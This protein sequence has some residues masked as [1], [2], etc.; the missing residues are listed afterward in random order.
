MP[1]HSV[2][3]IAEQLLDAGA[4]LAGSDPLRLLSRAAS[5]GYF[6][7]VKHLINAGTDVNAFSKPEEL[8]IVQASV[9]KNEEF[10]T[11]LLSAGANLHRQGRLGD[12]AIVQAARKGN[13]MMVQLL[14]QAK[15]DMNASDGTPDG[16][17]ALLAAIRKCDSRMISTASG[18]RRC[19]P[20]VSPQIG[21]YR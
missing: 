11:L 3:S 12:L 4:S 10:L 19:Q 16:E 2:I 18:S 5:E 9:K 21:A 1:E 8:P 17:T 15:A 13:A 20:Q 6:E 14:L 7:L